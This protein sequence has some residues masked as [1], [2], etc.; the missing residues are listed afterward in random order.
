MP[1]FCT[2]SVG[3]N[4]I[5]GELVRVE[6]DLAQGLPGTTLIGLGDTAVQQAKDRVR[7]ALVNSGETWPSRRITIALSPASLHKR[8]SAFDLPIAV[9]VLAAAGAVPLNS[10]DRGVWL[11]E[12]GLDGRVQAVRG[13]LPALL[14]ARASGVKFA[15][16]PM[17]NLAE[18][19]LV[20]GVTV[21]GAAS[22]RDVVRYL[23]GDADI[24][25][26]TGETSQGY[27]A[28]S[29][30]MADVL[31]QPEARAALELAAAGGHHVA[32]VGPPGAGKT[33]LA[34]RLPGILPPLTTEE[35]LKVTAVHSVAG[36]LSSNMPLV[37]MPPFIDPHHTASDVAIIGG[38]SGVIRPGSISLAHRGVLFLDE[39]PEFKRKVL[40]CL[41]QPMES[42]EV[43]I[44]RSTGVA[45]YP[46]RFQLILASNPCAC[47]AARDIDCTCAAGARMRYSGRLSGPLMDRID[48][49][50][51]LP[52]LD[53][54]S[55]AS[56]EPGEAS[57]PILERVLQAR[58]RA[59]RRWLGTTW[60][61]NSEVPGSMLRKTWRPSGEGA[62]LLD[63]AIRTGL[64]TGRGYDRV[65]RLSLT[66]ADLAERDV[67]CMSDI[68]T[69][70]GMRSGAA[71]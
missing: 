65:L 46:A 55:M 70:L 9:A 34:S 4:G 63:R 16:V 61:T 7:A 48:I 39:A 31:G 10:V 38:G 13:V 19:S 29:P 17:G 18:A 71:A 28:E 23:R 25:T 43:L 3:L 68:A 54:V 51:N 11:G 44:A 22:L 53:P 69:A 27:C 33:M 58:D 42:G 35:A 40:D 8:G 41:R 67:P 30:D 59:R 15:I 47:A 64:L 5:E 56:A 12:L 6:V 62:R 52:A 45:R 66:A 36:V 57:A 49:R 2:T 50:I 20:S 14:S 21:L 37:T 32:M 60:T 1:L 26:A 24:L